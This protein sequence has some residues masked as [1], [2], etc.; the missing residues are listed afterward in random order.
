MI[1]ISPA[2]DLLINLADR[3]QSG[4]LAQVGSR[5]V[6]VTGARAYRLPRN[7]DGLCRVRAFVPCESSERAFDEL[8]LSDAVVRVAIG[9]PDQ[10]PTSGIAPLAP[11]PSV[12]SGLLVPGKRYLIF[13][14]A[15]GDSFLNVGASANLAGTVFIASGTTPTAWTNGS[16]LFE[17][18]A[19]LNVATVTAAEMAAALNATA[20]ITA[21]GGVTVSSSSTFSSSSGG[22]S[23]FWVRYNLVG[24]RAAIAGPLTAGMTPKSIVSVSRV[25]P[26]I[27]SGVGSVH[28]VQLIRFLA[29]PYC[30]ATISTPAPAKAALVEE[31]IQSATQEE[32]ATYR[33]T[34]DPMA[35]DGHAIVDLDGEKFQ[36]PYNASRGYVQSKAGPK[37]SIRKKSEKAWDFSGVD[38]AQDFDLSVT[39]ESL[40]VP[41]G[42]TGTIETSTPG[43]L[44]AF[45]E[46]AAKWL[47]FTL[48]VDIQF[49][50]RK[51]FKAY[52]AEIE[53]PRDLIDLGSV[54][55]PTMLPL[56][57]NA[58]N[59]TEFPFDF[60]NQITSLRS[61]PASLESKATALLTFD[62]TLMFYVG[63][64]LNIW[65]WVPGLADVDDL[66]GQV[67][68]LDSV[69]GHWQKEGL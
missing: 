23:A 57:F 27:S 51:P 40:V 47:P 43:M 45:A 2:L 68:A 54:A 37:Y 13:T 3:N 58:S 11:V 15:P 41:G 25:E 7:C 18:T 10:A 66:D 69:L 46:T 61:G 30:F 8:N 21:L 44:Q 17:L 65:R 67:A 1:P 63:G 52:Q 26:G 12:T 19:D 20:G 49:P 64:T 48:A 62:F 55:P 53:V 5:I 39:V 24:P 4:R 56:Q 59:F 6:E 50:G 29:N 9:I 33:L 36:L 42:V 14:F 22:P 28:E 34:L 31:M 60:T 16:A 35:Y 32:P 38:P